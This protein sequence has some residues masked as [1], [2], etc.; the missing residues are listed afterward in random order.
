[1]LL[2]GTCYIPYD[3]NP[4]RK[5]HFVEA[6]GPSPRTICCRLCAWHV[7]STDP[8]I[9]FNVTFVAFHAPPPPS[10]GRDSGIFFLGLSWDGG[11]FKTS[12][13]LSVRNST[14]NKI[15]TEI[16]CTMY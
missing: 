3:G 9:Y 13:N 10:L 1:M 4:V 12:Q 16:V 5:H 15:H 7:G 14:E 8:Y 2:W 6:N 11:F